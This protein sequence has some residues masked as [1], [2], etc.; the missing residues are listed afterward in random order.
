MD[1]SF[2]DISDFNIGIG[3]DGQLPLARIGFQKDEELF[4]PGF[5]LV[6]IADKDEI[7]RS[8]RH[9]RS[10]KNIEER[11]KANKLRDE[12]YREERNITTFRRRIVRRQGPVRTFEKGL[13]EQAELT[14]RGGEVA[15]INEPVG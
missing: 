1:F 15:L 14:G 9:R 6:A 13:S 2:P 3:P 11:K 5:I 7:A 8:L 12:G 10:K 4:Q